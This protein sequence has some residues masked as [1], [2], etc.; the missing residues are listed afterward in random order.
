MQDGK[1]G[2]IDVFTGDGKGK[3]TAAFG[4]AFRALGWGYRVYVLQFMKL[5]TY[6]ENKSAIKFDDG[7]IVDFVGMPYFI[8][9]KGDIPDE[10]L[11]KV[12]NVLICEKGNPPSEY[13]EAVLN[14]FNRSLEELKTGRWDIFIYDE[15]NVALYYSLLKMD[16]VMRIFELKPEHTEL[17]FTGRKMPKEIMDRADLVTEVSSPK[18]PYQRG[19]LARRG[20]D[21]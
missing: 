18:H 12:K 17:V 2:L 11:K 14:H 6:G 15:I 1:L 8:A 3:T 7:L 10:D 9:W 21:F 16:E 13:R 4:L 5:G 20:I 19:I